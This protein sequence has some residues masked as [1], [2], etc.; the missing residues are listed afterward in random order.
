MM[1]GRLM[2]MEDHQDVL[3]EEDL[4]DLEDHLDQ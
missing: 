3:I 1:E 2:E 4:Q